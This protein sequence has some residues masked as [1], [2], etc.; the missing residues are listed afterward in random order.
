MC[1]LLV[2]PIHE[3]D[4]IL[5]IESADVYPLFIVQ[6]INK[7]GIL[8]DYH[9]FGLTFGY[10]IICQSLLIISRKCILCISAEFT[11]IGRI[12]EYEVIILRLY[13]P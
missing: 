10:K 2:I 8:Y 9:P 4:H 1:D 13:H 3:A 7:A 11:I 6:A 5:F 12:E